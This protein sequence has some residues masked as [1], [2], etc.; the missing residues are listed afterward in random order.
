[1]FVCLQNF[2]VRH[3]EECSALYL[4]FQVHR[5]E[6]LLQSKVFVV[7]APHLVLIFVVF[8][9]YRESY[10]SPVSVVE[11]SAT[12]QTSRDASFSSQF[13]SRLSAK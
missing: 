7:S 1:M 13:H 9:T 2:S 10:D 11:T 8:P 5:E 6:A 4:Q 12:R 3:D